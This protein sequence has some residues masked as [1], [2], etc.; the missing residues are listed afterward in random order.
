VHAS[1]PGGDFSP[2]SGLA[3]CMPLISIL[4][5]PVAEIARYFHISGPAVSMALD[6]GEQIALKHGLDK[7]IN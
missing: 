7:L 2:L 4:E 5:I 1:A 3:A 6:K